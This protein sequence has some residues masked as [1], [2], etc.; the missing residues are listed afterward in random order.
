MDRSRERSR[1]SAVHLL[2]SGR[3]Q[4]VGFRWF[5]IQE[6]QRAGLTG[7][8]RNLHDGR[9]EAWLEG[10][11]EAVRAVEAAV[12]R[13]PRRA[14]VKGVER[15]DERPAGRYRDFGPGSEEP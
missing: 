4:G 14:E 15:R 5:V 7:W 3:V 1:L 8:V 12:G 6:A 11:E 13:G 2:V 9:V 10:D